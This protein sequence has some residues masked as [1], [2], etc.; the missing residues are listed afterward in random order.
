MTPSID[1]RLARASILVMGLSAAALAPTAAGASEDASA[2]EAGK[3]IAFTR[4]LGNC[5]ACHV[6]PGGESPGTIGPPLVAM[7][8]RY[9]DKAKLREQ[10]WDATQVNPTSAMP[11]FGKNEILTEEQIDQLV[12]F[13]YT[14]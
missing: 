7:Q 2:L 1:R 8:A 13:I 9:P 4:S 12:D 14:L 11:P 6:M 3:K 5:I 10:I